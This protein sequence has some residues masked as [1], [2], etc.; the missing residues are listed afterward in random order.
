MGFSFTPM[1]ADDPELLDEMQLAST[2]FDFFVELIS[3]EINEGRIYSECLPYQ[4]GAFF[5]KDANQVSANAA[6]AMDYVRQACNALFEFQAFA[7]KDEKSANLIQNAVWPS[8]G[9]CMEVV[10]ILREAHFDPSNFPLFLQKELLNVGRAPKT[11][12]CVEDSFRELGDAKLSHTASQLG[13]AARWHRCVNSNVLEE[14]D[15]KRLFV[16]FEDKAMARKLHGHRGV[17]KATFFPVAA[18]D[19]SIP[20]LLEH[21]MDGK[22]VCP[23]PDTFF[24]T[25]QITANMIA[26]ASRPA[27]LHKSWLSLLVEPKTFLIQKGLGGIRGLALSATEHCVVLWR[28]EYAKDAVGDKFWFRLDK[29]T[30]PGICWTQHVIENVDNYLVMEMQALPPCVGVGRFADCSMDHSKC[31]VICPPLE[32]QAMKL[33]DYAARHAFRTLN[34]DQMKKLADE[35]KLLWPKPKPKTEFD[36]ARF[37]MHNFLP[38]FSSIQVDNLIDEFRHARK[39]SV[40]KSSFTAGNVDLVAKVVDTDGAA[41][42]K[43]RVATKAL[44]KEE[45]DLQS[46]RA[47]GK[48]TARQKY[49]KRSIGDSITHDFTCNEAKEWCPQVLGCNLSIDDKKHMR[50]IISY[51]NKE[52]PFATSAVWNADVTSKQALYHC[53]RWAWE[54]HE[55]ATTEVNPYDFVA[56]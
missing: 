40:W 13:R 30:D 11:T 49:T 17:P 29:L 12:K 31:I 20:E 2:C 3:R 51:P 22:F 44:D 26:F 7:L 53:L 36:I 19:S 4:F 56:D 39:P 52:S 5:E 34:V 47:A 23:P 37:L 10:T 42:A 27:A 32:S 6:D 54:C 16:T 46:R 48:R 25:A 28:G 15:R 35:Y 43:E 21:F 18:E 41:L 38:K 8:Q 55:L 9:W 45:R 1:A 24:T 14:A 50:W 33:V